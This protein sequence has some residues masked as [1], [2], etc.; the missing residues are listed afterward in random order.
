MALIRSFV[1]ATFLFVAL[2]T[3]S[4]IYFNFLFY[5]IIY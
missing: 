5:L 1:V 2:V 3:K 4:L